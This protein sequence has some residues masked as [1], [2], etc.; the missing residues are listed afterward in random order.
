MPSLLLC[1]FAEFGCYYWEV[2]SFL[3]ENGGEVDVGNSAG[4]RR[5]GSSGRRGGCIW[6]V[7]YESSI[8]KKKEKHEKNKKLKW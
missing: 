2:C 1:S 4:G 7:L 5:P 3:K 8:E 6:N